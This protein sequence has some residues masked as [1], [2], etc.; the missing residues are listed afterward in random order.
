M[1]FLGLSENELSA[2]STFATAVT[3]IV[4]VVVAFMQILIS[5]KESRLGIA[6]GIYKDYLMYAFANPQFSSASY[7]LDEPRFDTFRK[8]SDE[9]EKYEF[10]VSYLLFAA[11]EVL[12]LTK[13][14]YGWR[15][16]LCDQLKYHALYL[17]S[18]DLPEHHY[19]SALLTLRE[20]A[21]VAYKSEC[22]CNESNR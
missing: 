22:G 17:D 19:S 4:A 16:T 6:K 11:E 12:E 20:D 14:N 5:K 21:I 13:N 15:A 9:Y 10:F 18:L 7:P 1:L 3:A 8:N 2:Y